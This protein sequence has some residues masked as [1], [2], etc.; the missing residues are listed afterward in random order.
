MKRQF[1][2][3]LEPIEISGVKLKN[4]MVKPGQGM[5]YADKEGYMTD[6]LLGFYDSIARGGVGLINLEVCSVDFPLGMSGA[7]HLRIDDD[8]FMSGLSQMATVIHKG[9]CPVFLQLGHAGHRHPKKF[10]GAQ[11]VAAS[12]LS[13]DDAPEILDRDYT[14]PKELTS[15]EIEELICKFAKAAERARKAGYEGVEVHACHDYLING[16]LSLAWNR[17]QDAY[18]C[19]D[20]TS[21]SKFLVDIIKAI[22]KRAG[23]DYPVGV[24]INGAEYGIKGGI[25]PEESQRFAQIAQKAGAAYIHV[26]A[27]GYGNYTRLIYPEQIFYP[28]PPKPLA[29]SLDKNNKG[30]GALAPLAAA[31]KKAVSVPVITVGRFDAFLADK[32]IREG[33]ADLV[34]FGRQLFADPEFPNKIAAGRIEDVAP[35]MACLECRNK[36]SLSEGVQCRVNV[37]LG[38]EREC[39]IKPAE[40]K[41]KVLVVGGGPAGMEAARVAALRGHEVVLYEKDHDLGGALPLAVLVKGD[42][43]EKIPPLVSYLRTQLTKLG[44]KVRFGK[45]ADGSVIEDVKPDVV[46]LANGGVPAIPEIPGIR[47]R[48]V[49]STS[50]LH[51]TA[52]MFL[53]LFGP[54][55]LRALTR[56]WM[57]FGKNVVVI[58]GAIQGCE[59]AEFLVK[60]GRKVTMVETSEKMGAGMVEINS[61]RLLRWLGRKGVTMLTG[62]QYNE[63][64]DEGVVI[65]S[66]EGKKETIKADTVALA[67]GLAPNLQLLKTVEGKAP[68]IY[69]IGDCSKPG[70]ILD[71]IHEGSRIARKI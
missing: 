52:K 26:S 69:S 19:K 37:A 35:C 10:A 48:N 50:R 25:T 13:A 43:V 34:A 60:R 4:R 1:E 22:K 68:E 20:I 40:K 23:E 41:K 55:F 59:L 63:I 16:F 54:A 32:A 67:T 21:R 39:V 70:L 46:I 14:S 64:T 3:L 58:G 49:L 66:K 8:R 65:T 30:A 62:V 42:D 7:G 29:M 17:R 2:K 18:G 38:R 53:R 47:G 36:T 6:R 61:V 44:I 33:K 56:L 9:G 51:K 57:P 45:E 24:R 5:R 71:A 28:E 11:P 31:V 27:Y 12:S 15:S